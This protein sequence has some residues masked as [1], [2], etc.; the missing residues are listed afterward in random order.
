MERER[1]LE[2]NYPSPI[3]TDKTATDI[4]YNVG[5]DYCI[6]NINNISLF[7]EWHNEQSNNKVTHLI[8]DNGLDRN[9]ERIWSALL[10][11][12]SDNISY[13]LAY[14]GFNVAKYFP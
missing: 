11:G 1:A 12:M 3:Q 2:M 10:Y 14:A 6:D 8:E 13:N 5:L 9:D 7:N 4:D